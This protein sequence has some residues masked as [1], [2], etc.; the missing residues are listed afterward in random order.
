VE[1]FA[2]APISNTIEEGGGRITFLGQGVLAGTEQHRDVG[3]G[4][5][6]DALDRH[7]CP[8]M[9]QLDREWLQ[10]LRDAMGGG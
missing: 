2:H 10:R 1:G 4:M 6:F 5:T 7:G 3:G 8:E 9:R